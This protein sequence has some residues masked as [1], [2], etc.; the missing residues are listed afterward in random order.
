MTMTMMGMMIAM[1]IIV[2]DDDDICNDYYDHNYTNDF[3]ISSF[4]WQVIFGGG[5]LNFL[6]NSSFD[7]VSNKTGLRTDD[8]NLLEVEVFVA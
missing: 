7:E 3:P 5:S 6:P 2:D 1:A 8:R 4:S